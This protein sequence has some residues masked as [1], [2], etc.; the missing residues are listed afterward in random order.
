MTQGS[1]LITEL[2]RALGR[3]DLDPA[4]PLAE[5]GV[6]ENAIADALALVGLAAG[7]PR[8]L[9]PIVTLASLSTP[10][11]SEVTPPRSQSSAPATFAQ[12]FGQDLSEL[13]PDLPLTTAVVGVRLKGPLDEAVLQR[14][15]ATVVERHPG[16]RTMVQGSND[17]LVQVKAE[18]WPTMT[19]RDAALAPGDGR[20][21]AAAA[22]LRRETRQPFDARRAAPVRVSLTRFAPDDHLLILA[23]NDAF[24]DSDSTW[25][26]LS[27]LAASY[28]E[29]S[30]A[31]PVASGPH[32]L[33]SWQHETRVPPA[34]EVRDI[35]SAA[36][37]EAPWTPTL[38][39]D[40]SR[41]P[42]RSYLAKRVSFRL[43]EVVS[44]RVNALAASLHEAPSAVL[45]AA[46]AVQLSRSAGRSDVALVYEPRGR[47]RVG[48]LGVVT[49]MR[50]PVQVRLSVNPSAPFSDVIRESAKVLRRSREEQAG[51]RW[52][53]EADAHPLMARLSGESSDYPLV[54]SFAMVPAPPPLEFKGLT[55]TVEVEP[56]AVTLW[57]VALTLSA[58]RQGYTG[59]LTYSQEQFSEQTAQRMVG[60]FETA[61]AGLTAS[62]Q[63][64][65]FRTGL[66]TAA[67]AEQVLRTWNATTERFAT[68]VGVHGLFERQVDRTPDAVA[69]RMGSRTLTYRQLDERANQVAHWLRGAG[70]GPEDRV[71]MALAS[72]PEAIAAL[73]GV[74]KAGGAYVPLDPETPVDRLQAI[75]RDAAVKAVIA[76][77]GTLAAVGAGL[78]RPLPLA[79]F[80]SVD[81]QPKGRLGGA[82]L[83]NQL[84]Y[85][86][87]TSGSTG[88]PKGVL[89]EHRSVVNHNQAIA[90][91]L[92]LR[93]EDRVLQF[94]PLNFDAA[95]EEIYPPLCVG[96]S[97][98]VRREL[99]AAT[100]LS[101][102]I[103]AEGLSVLSL[104]PAYMHQWVQHLFVTAQPPPAALRL[105]MLGG[106]RILP[107]TLALWQQVGGERIPWVN[108]YGP[109]E[110]T[111]TSASSTLRA[112]VALLDAQLPIGKP[113]ANARLYLLGPGLIPVPQGHVG[114]I[115]IGGAGL[116]R[117][118]LGRP[119][120]T[121]E[122]FV[123]DP[124]SGEAGGRLYRTGDLGRAMPDGR[125]VF[126]GRAESMV[127][128]RGFRVE[129][130]DVE[131]NLRRHPSVDGAVVVP[132][133]DGA[134][135]AK[136]WAY[137]TAKPTL[138]VT[139]PEVRNWLKSVV[140]D[141]MIPA[142]LAVLPTFPLTTNGKI[143]VKALPSLSDASQQGAGNYAGPRNPTEEKLAAIWAE[144]LGVAK[145]G[146]HDDF[147][148]LGGQ[149]LTA[150]KLVSDCQQLA[151]IWMELQDVF[152]A[153]TIA[154]LTERLGL[155]AE[156]AVNVDNL[157]DEQVE[158]EL[159][160]L[161]A[162]GGS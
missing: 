109:T 49:S 1:G 47:D 59:A 58:S 95:G 143:D 148:D 122:R 146:I 9:S 87:Y 90:R 23:A 161:N 125:M 15:F 72:G 96:A 151:G 73:Y 44:A 41:P 17:A 154:K 70:V 82:V 129:L 93:P 28:S 128:I 117:G 89:V 62:P 6:D 71:A 36:L 101:A 107:E 74:L 141:Y 130:G 57:P 11:T 40:F 19:R 39:T 34:G 60:H 54:G 69:V 63:Q 4:R 144:V 145:V 88:V 153:P 79:D 100:E 150:M 77:P 30:L 123:P 31:P 137:V 155:G 7:A 104:P 110:A 64:P 65:V 142:A 156:P 8:E 38:P 159:R 32:L 106:E 24:V 80:T 66:L 35:V 42:H 112:E 83:P 120:Q 102:V 111:I 108:V 94:T 29:R 152:E 91:V 114:E 37:S 12:R 127:K 43:S 116:A 105:I 68:D 51:D 81:G 45:F 46:L 50:Q 92:E 10:S 5:Q 55:A 157:T 133:E 113:V 99:I 78:G 135:G 67:E 98:V 84:A 136:L 48:L 160:K 138:T 61:L 13:A 27:E 121:A 25:Q 21:E 33:G 139:W 52:L 22:A 126:V 56:R 18:P 20:E 103:E 2:K 134:S 16:L 26:V 119:E 85:V 115:Y 131:A 149:S 53:S 75:L 147:F 3:A 14:A 132:V 76:E 162:G 118:Y 124:F 158:E 86:V 97:T 140:P